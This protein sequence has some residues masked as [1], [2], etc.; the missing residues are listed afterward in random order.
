MQIAPI[1]PDGV[2][3]GVHWSP[4]IRWAVLDIVLT[5]VASV[6]VIFYLAGAEP[7]SGDEEIS[8]QAL[9]AAMASPEFL[10][11][12]FAV[13][14]SITAYA[15]FRA[16][17]AAGTLHIRHGGWTAAVSAVLG[18]FFLFLPGSDSVPPAPLWY[19]ALSL[20][21][22]FPAGLL[23]GWFASRQARP[24]AQFRA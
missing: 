5:L 14:L 10:L 7:S 20:A 11:W 1:E 3:D 24:A 21:L 23:G 19:D 17:R 9:D 4:I 13:G 8:D 16:S 22:M 2:F 15:S 6:P 12:G 18:L